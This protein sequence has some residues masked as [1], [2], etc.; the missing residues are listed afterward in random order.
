[1]YQQEKTKQ[2]EFTIDILDKLDGDDEFLNEF[3]F[4]GED[5]FHVLS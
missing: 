3:F 1:M 5:T 2:F 4:T